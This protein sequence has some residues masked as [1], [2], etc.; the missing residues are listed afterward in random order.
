VLITSAD[1]YSNDVGP[2]RERAVVAAGHR[3][4]FTISRWLRRQRERGERERRKR[5]VE[6]W[7]HA[8]IVA[9]SVN[10]AANVVSARTVASG[11]RPPARQF[12][13]GRGQLAHQR[14]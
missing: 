1:G 10:L 12:G 2:A 9:T 5:Y 11:V 14:K 7:W 13:S 4:A 6:H 3:G 8:D